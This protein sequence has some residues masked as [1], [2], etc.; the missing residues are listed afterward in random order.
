MEQQDPD[1]PLAPPPP[2]GAKTTQKPFWNAEKVLGL[3][4]LLVSIASV[5]AIF[6]Q[7]HLMQKQQYASVLPYLEMWNTGGGGDYRLLLIN[8]G[9]GPAFVKDVQ[10][11]Y[12]G[13]AYK[14][15]HYNFW[16]QEVYQPDSTKWNA[17]FAKDSAV[18]QFV[19]SNLYK[20]RVLKPGEECAL[21]TIN[22]SPE[23]VEAVRGMFGSNTALLRITYTSVYGE[24]WR[25]EGLG[26]IPVK[27]E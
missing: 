22:K 18:Y 5:S 17:L 10:V 1:Q 24:E 26:G 4:A 19:Y 2:A 8:N 20:G 11:Q 7:T 12:K 9:T 16:T 25:L 14:M 6:Y 27:Q 23:M 3:S 13:K 21:F 15:D